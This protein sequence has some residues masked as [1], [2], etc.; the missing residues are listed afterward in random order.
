MR[1]LMS[2]VNWAL[3]MHIHIYILR[4]SSGILMKVSNLILKVLLQFT[5]L[6]LVA[7]RI[8]VLI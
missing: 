5:E 4:F 8:P 7:P 1:F 3:A 6:E 2:H